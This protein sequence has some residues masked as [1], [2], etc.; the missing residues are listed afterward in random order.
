MAKLFVGPAVSNYLCS[1]HEIWQGRA[2][3][4]SLLEK[5]KKKDTQKDPENMPSSTVYGIPLPTKFRQPQIYW[6]FESPE[7]ITLF[8]DTDP[9]CEMKLARMKDI[10]VVYSMAGLNYS[11]ILGFLDS[12]CL[13]CFAFSSF[14]FMLPSNYKLP[15]VTSC[16]SSCFVRFWSYNYR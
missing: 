8:P 3:F 4:R 15:R 14:L 13:L 12:G 5:G 2:C 9:N 1:S 11:I 7:T 6:P 16:S 10:C